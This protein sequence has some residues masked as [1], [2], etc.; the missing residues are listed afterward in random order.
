VKEGLS[1]EKLC[2]VTLKA[3]QSS[4]LD[5]QRGNYSCASHSIT[6]F[7]SESTHRLQGARPWYLVLR[8]KIRETKDSSRPG[9]EQLISKVEKRQTW[10]RAV[11]GGE[12]G[13]NEALRVP[14][15]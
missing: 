1:A 6:Q 9:D 15:I 8:H 13:G 10:A 12:V 3:N 7:S 14:Y 4:R 11:G 2:V 5:C